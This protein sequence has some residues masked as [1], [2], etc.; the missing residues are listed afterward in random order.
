ML[1]CLKNMFH[2]SGDFWRSLEEIAESELWQGIRDM[3]AK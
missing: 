1:I 2:E 3:L